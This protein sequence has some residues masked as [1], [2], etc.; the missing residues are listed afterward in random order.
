[1][2]RV[3][4]SPFLQALSWGVG[5]GL[6]VAAGAYLTSVS[7]SGAPGPA[8]LDVFETVQLPVASGLVTIVVV[9]VIARV[10]GAIRLGLS[11][12]QGNERESDDSQSQHDSVAG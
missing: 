3:A 12:R 2:A 10:I 9:Y 1:M 7:G 4:G 6:G 8:S 11:S 5:V